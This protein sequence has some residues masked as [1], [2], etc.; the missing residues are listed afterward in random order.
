MKM[1]IL[2]PLSDENKDNQWMG[3]SVASTGEFPGTAVVSFCCQKIV[4]DIIQKRFVYTFLIFLQ[5][6]RSLV[7]SRH[8]KLWVWTL[9]HDDSITSGT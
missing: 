1:D 3:V 2:E 4:I 5:G 6:M 8:E 9:L 7:Q